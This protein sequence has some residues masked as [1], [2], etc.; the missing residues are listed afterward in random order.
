MCILYTVEQKKL[1]GRNLKHEEREKLP[2]VIE[3]YKKLCIIIMVSDTPP[4][5]LIPYK[6]VA[7]IHTV[8]TNNSPF[9]MHWSKNTV[10]S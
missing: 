5:P 7:F 4:P 2:A 10:N 6:A 1:V 9:I 3:Y 8:F